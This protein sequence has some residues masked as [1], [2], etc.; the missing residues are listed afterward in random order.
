MTH[1]SQYLLAFTI[2]LEDSRVCLA[3]LLLLLSDHI[4]F[5]A[6]HASS[7]MSTF[8]LCGPFC[9]G[10]VGFHPSFYPLFL[11]HLIVLIYLLHWYILEY[12]S[13]TSCLLVILSLISS[14]LQ[15]PFWISSFLPCI[16]SI[17]KGN[18][19]LSFFHIHI[20]SM[21]YSFC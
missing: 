5:T 10:I 4:S 15:P 8:Y 17:L 16:F 11:H 7:C 21:M 6:V 1:G 2:L 3:L 19:P 20:S 14:L 12:A 9:S 13:S 18:A